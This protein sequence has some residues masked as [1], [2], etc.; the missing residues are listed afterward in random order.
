MLPHLILA[1]DHLRIWSP[2]RR[3]NQP[4]TV[5]LSL[6]RTEH[7]QT[8][9]VDWLRST[10]FVFDSHCVCPDRLSAAVWTGI[11]PAKSWKLPPTQSTAKRKLRVC[12]SALCHEILC[13]GLWAAW[14]IWLSVNRGSKYN[15]IA[16]S[17]H[18]PKNW[19]LS[20][21]AWTRPQEVPDVVTDWFLQAI[22]QRTALRF[23][24]YWSDENK[25]I[26]RS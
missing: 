9:E 5:T 7:P 16:I 14:Q 8:S 18:C 13:R 23:A 26:R 3:S 17:R 1:L 6:V 10:S 15:P 25:V 11:K 24:L 2:H 12:L 20:R 22:I 21:P 4:F 19:F